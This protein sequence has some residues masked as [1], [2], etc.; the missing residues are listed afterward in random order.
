MAAKP[1]G[2]AKPKAKTN[3]VKGPKKKVVFQEKVEE[4]QMEESIIK[5]QKDS[6]G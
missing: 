4:L 6:D 5:D 1:K 2:V 3:A